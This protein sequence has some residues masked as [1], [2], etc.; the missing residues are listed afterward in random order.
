MKK[1]KKED[2]KTAITVG[3]DDLAGLQALVKKVTSLQTYVGQLEI[4]KHQTLHQVAGANDE[5]LLMRDALTKKYG[6]ADINV[7]NGNINREDGKDN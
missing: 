2:S 5:I 6:T 1:V 4:T 3:K 7:E